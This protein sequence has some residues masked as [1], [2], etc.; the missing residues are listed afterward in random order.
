MKSTSTLLT[1]RNIINTL[2]KDLI[3]LL[4]KRQKIAVKIAKTKA[5]Q[6]YPIKD[7]EREQLLLNNL[8]ALG[9]ENN[10]NSKYISDLFKIIINNSVL[11]QKNWIKHNYCKQIKLEIF[12]FLGDSGS[13]SYDATLK[14]ANKKHQFFNKNYCNTF[15]EIVENVENGK[16]DYAVLPIENNSSGS[17]N[18]TYSILIN[19]KL[20]IVGEIN[21]PI[22]HCLLSKPKTQLI[23]IKTVYSHK[24]PFIQCSKFIEHF[25]NWKLKYTNST[26]DAI[27]KVYNDTKFTSAALG[28]EACKKIY[29]LKIISKNISNLENN[30]T[31]FIILHKTDIYVPEHI[32]SIT[33]IM[34]LINNNEYLI[35]KIINTIK[36]H[37]IKIRQLKSHKLLETSS[38]IIIFID[39]K[40]NIN[41]NQM[42]N[43]LYKLKNIT[44]IKVL[45]CYPIDK[46]PL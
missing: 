1:L 36:E 30:I 25:P 40:N 4:A 23:N 35:K 11:I 24:Q 7:I 26:T 10:L 16:S 8:I 17:I 44:L 41:V 43:T 5:Q 32:P 20:S 34:I 18:E 9:Q 19:T 38:E 3:S 37:N 33:T 28:N 46:F 22:N 12:S 13:Y 15:Q 39:I 45:G 6:N 29:Q 42:K 31:R 2:D 14:Y 27:K 21:I